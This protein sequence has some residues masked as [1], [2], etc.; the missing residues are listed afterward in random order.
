M[1]TTGIY[2]RRMSVPAVVGLVSALGLAAIGVAVVVV[3]KLPQPASPWHLETP[4]VFL[5][6]VLAAA[7]AEVFS[8]P[9]VHGDE[10]EDLTFFEIV[11]VAAILV[12]APEWA[13]VATLLG[14]LAVQL[15]L[16]I[17]PMKVAFNLGSYATA[18][19][20]ALITYLVVTG[21][22]EPFSGRGVVGLVLG[23]LMFSLVNTLLLAAVLQASEGVPYHEV[24]TDD[25]ALPVLQAVAGVAVGSV[26]V[27]LAPVSVWL[28]PFALM[29]AL[30]LWYA[31][32]SVSQRAEE[33]ERNRWLV[34]L[35]GIL[36]AE[37]PI[38]ELLA[39]ASDAIRAAFGSGA[40]RVLLPAEGDLSTT[41]T[42]AEGIVPVPATRLPQG[43][44][45]AVSIGLELGDGRRGALL[46]GDTAGARHPW[47]L[48]PTDEAVLTTVAASLGSAIRS[49]E[50]HAALVEETSKLKAVVENASDGIAVLSGTGRIRLWSPA[51]ARIT[52]VTEEVALDRFA[53]PPTALTAV[54]ATALVDGVVVGQGP[55]EVE[56]RPFTITRPD[57]ETRDISVAVVRARAN[58][59]GEPVAILTVHDVTSQARADRLKSDFVATIS[60]ELRTPI[61]PI[62]GYAQL[63]LARGDAMTPEKRR[64]AYELI[65]DR[66]DHLGR[67][68]EDL[69]MASRASGTL[70]SKLATTPQGH[71]LRTIV[72]AATESFPAMASRLVVEQ[73]DTSVPVWCDSVRSVQILSNL[74]SNAMKYS[75]EGTPITVRVPESEF[76]DTHAVVTV[77]DQGCG[78]AAGD[79]ERVFE[80]FY[81]VEDSMTMRT[82]GSGLGLYIARELAVAMGGSLTVTSQ[83][84]QGS[85]FTVRLPRTEAAATATTPAPVPAPT[86]PFAR[87]A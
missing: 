77:T 74:L 48:K 8:V 64:S 84:G 28:M 81:R 41:F 5:F 62:K 15:V 38:P 34:T 14:L 80:R 86:V 82:S 65:A 29:P 72:S 76:G 50:R 60:H 7:L 55:A 22:G 16:R 18:T 19:V 3:P 13:V 61:T 11:T 57:G 85:T 51:L 44:G 53:E 6:F 83:P 69:L 33:R 75:P 32:R 20:A 35:S 23:M 43:W 9:L 63:L 25:W 70:G 54:V 56:P 2:G 12:L 66:A 24:V 58:T 36:T 21:G 30:T 37:A 10:K 31:Y 52:G 71:D 67:L 68:V 49:A 87:T 17:P 26:S 73:P 40:V 79:L 47:T 46:L 39:D 78:L 42:A 27:A 59:D 45:S 4:W 1:T